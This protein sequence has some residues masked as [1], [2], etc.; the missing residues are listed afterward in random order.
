MNFWI[1]V[2]LV[3]GV[4]LCNFSVFL[5]LN[6]WDIIWLCGP[7]RPQAHHYVERLALS[8]Q[9]SPQPRWVLELQAFATD[10][11]LILQFGSPFSSFWLVLLRVC[12]S[13][14]L[15]K[16]PSMSSLIHLKRWFLNDI[17][18]ISDLNFFLLVLGAPYSHFSKHVQCIVGL[19]L[20]SSLFI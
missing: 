18:L 1:S 9:S 16:E 20:W 6:F 8:S 19:F 15:F 5:S 11:P 17:L 10:L 7:D 14:T 2:L 3:I 13:L 12:E 4:L